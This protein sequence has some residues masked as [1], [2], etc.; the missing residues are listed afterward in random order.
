MIK[1]ILDAGFVLQQRDYLARR[2]QSEAEQL[3]AGNPESAEM[4][5][6]FEVEEEDLRAAAAMLADASATPDDKTCFIPGDQALSLLQASL[7]EA[8]MTSG[9]VQTEAISGLDAVGGKVAITDLRLPPEAVTKAVTDGFVAGSTSS[10]P[11]YVTQFLLARASRLFRRRPP[12]RDQPARA[13]IANRA[14]VILFGDWGSGVP[15]AVATARHIK[16]LLTEKPDYEGHAIHIG[17][18]YFAGFGYEY[19]QRALPFWPGTDGHSWA[20][21]G[22]HDMYTGGAGFLNDFLADPKFSA[23]QAKHW[24]V[25]ENDNWQIFGLDSAYALPGATGQ[26]GELAGTQ[27]QQVHQIRTAS[28]G[29]GGIL[30]T[31]HQPFNVSAGAFEIHSPK[32]VDAL[33]PVLHANLVRGW[34]WGHEHDAAVYKP[35][36]NVAYP[37]LTGHAGVPEAFKQRSLDGQQRWR[38]SDHLA[39]TD[40]DYFSMGFTVLDFDEG[41]CEVSFYNEDGVRQ[42]FPDGRHVITKV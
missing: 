26:R 28:P 34:F 19:K 18:I 8:Y 5:E 2:L 23:Q 10:D 4:A 1:E 3:Q 17:D 11:R 39:T 20:I 25:L 42:P 35:W 30:L 38:W 9:L 13:T 32:M 14:R 33:Q 31:H 36:N 40:G 27:A 6:K 16:R 41:S 15:R 12:F 29:K 37:C 21:A 22:N 24:F 7:N